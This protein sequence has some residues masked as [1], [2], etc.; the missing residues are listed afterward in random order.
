MSSTSVPAPAYPTPFVSTADN[1]NSGYFIDQ[2]GYEDVAVLALRTFVALDGVEIPFQSV[3]TYFIETAAALGKTKLII[4]VSANGGGII[5]EGIDLFKQLFPSSDPYEAN[6]YRAHEAINLLGEQASYLAGLVPR[7]LDDN[8]TY[9]EIESSS[10]NYR[11]DTDVN[12][13]PFNSWTEKYGPDTLGPQP[14]NFTSL[15]RWN[16]SDVLTPLQ[17]GGIYVSGYLNRTNITVQPFA[18]ENIVIV[19]IFE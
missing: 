16:L 12:G 1:E 3:N 4:D 14:D 17:G 5:L 18:P 7:S 11:T 6:R 9:Q 15:F 10:Y 2:P 19:S 13:Q 8:D